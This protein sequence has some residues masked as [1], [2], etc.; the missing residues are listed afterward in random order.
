MKFARCRRAG[1]VFNWWNDWELVQTWVGSCHAKLLYKHRQLL[2]LLLVGLTACSTVPCRSRQ[3]IELAQ[4]PASP[5]PPTA[6]LIFLI[7]TPLLAQRRHGD[8]VWF[9]FDDHVERTAQ[10][11]CVCVCV[12]KIDVPHHSTP[13]CN[14]MPFYILINSFKNKPIYTNC[15]FV[16]SWQ[17]LTSVVINMST[18][19]VTALPCEMQTSIVC[20]K[21]GIGLH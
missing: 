8:S 9:M 11:V 4:T 1:I 20:S 2:L 3:D 17:H 14:V 6:T 19:N 16:E 10:C 21:S 18:T 13:T 7:P 5:P 12:C 15:W